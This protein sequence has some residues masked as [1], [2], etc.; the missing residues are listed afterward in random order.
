[1]RIIAR[2]LTDNGGERG[3]SECRGDLACG[4]KRRS[5]GRRPRKSGRRREAAGRIDRELAGRFTPGQRR[6]RPDGPL[7]VSARNAYALC[8]VVARSRPPETAPT[9]NPFSLNCSFPGSQHDSVHDGPGSEHAQ[10]GSAQ[11]WAL[12]PR[13]VRRQHH[14]KPEKQKGWFLLTEFDCF[15]CNC[16]S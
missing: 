6:S 5:R 13:G 14:T 16:I 12:L 7:F 11:R 10:A 9:L 15:R 1:M 8:P 3:R 2:Q 4:P